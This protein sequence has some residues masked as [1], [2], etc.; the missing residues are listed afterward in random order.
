MTTLPTTVTE[1]KEPETGEGEALYLV[2]LSLFL[3]LVHEPY[4]SEVKSGEDNDSTHFFS[5]LSS[6]DDFSSRGGY[7]RGRDFDD[8]RRREPS[9][10]NRR[11]GGSPVSGLQGRR[12]RSRD[13]LMAIERDRERG[14]GRGGGRDAY[15]D[16]F[17]R[18]AME[19]KR[20][21]EQQRAR[22]RERLDSDSERS[23]RGRT[24]RGPPP[25][26]MSPPSNYPDRR[27]DDNYPAPLPPPYI[28]DDESLTSSKKSNLRKVSQSSQGSAYGH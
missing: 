22:S 14:G 6:D 21:G 3:L 1:E 5:P 11:R 26:P 2:P 13:D 18:E 27:Y 7:D 10:D 24:P 12:S 17:Q 9:P 19:K 20:L 25:L 23:D 8:R 15:D 28:S 16:S 4:F